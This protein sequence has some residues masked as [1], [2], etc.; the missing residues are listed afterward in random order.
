MSVSTCSF[1]WEKILILG[2]CHSVWNSLDSSWSPWGGVINARQGDLNTC[3]LVFLSVSVAWTR[4]SYFLA[5]GTTLHLRLEVRCMHHTKHDLLGLWNSW[6]IVVKCMLN[7][8][9]IVY[10][11][12]TCYFSLANYGHLIIVGFFY[13]KLT[14]A[15][16]YH[17]VGTCDDHEPSFVG[18]DGQQ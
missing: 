5:N 2:A 6:W 3:C 13:N 18:A 4:S 1:P 16:L 14:L 7:W 8:L 10:E 17:V 15:I 12:G 9:I 11:H